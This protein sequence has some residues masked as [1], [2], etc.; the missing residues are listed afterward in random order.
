MQ[1]YCSVDQVRISSGLKNANR[2]PAENVFKAIV[3]ACTLVNS[4]L[5]NK[6]ILPIPYHRECDLTFSGTGDSSG[7]LNITVN[8]TVYPIA[9]TNLMTAAQVATA[10]Y[11]VSSQDFYTLYDSVGNKVKIISKSD[12][13][14]L[15]VADA[16]VTV[17]TPSPTAGITV[18][19]SARLD[20]VIPFVS[21]LTS[22]I[23]AAILLDNN[24][25]LEAENTTADSTKRWERINDFLNRLAS[26]TGNTSIRLVDEFTQQGIGLRELGGPSGLPNYTTNDSRY[27]STE[28]IV[29][30]DHDF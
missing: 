16:Q 28:P 12:S 27:G 8:G 20:R 3:E 26:I 19:V 17:T 29:R 24:Y 5:V 15:V 9:I 2:I 18:A 7:T 14:N 13:A 23:A 4:A 30:M 1:L 6:Y 21:E 22:D 11:L 25:S 10:F